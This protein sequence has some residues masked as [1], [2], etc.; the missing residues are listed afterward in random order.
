MARIKDTTITTAKKKGMTPRVK[1][2]KKGKSSKRR[3]WK[4]YVKKY[5]RRVG[6]RNSAYIGMSASNKRKAYAYARKTARYRF[7]K[8]MYTRTK[9]SL[10]TWRDKAVKTGY[11]VK[12]IRAK[13]QKAENTLRKQSSKV[14]RI[15][16][17]LGTYRRKRISS[18]RKYSS[19]KK[20]HNLK[21]LITKRRRRRRRS[22]PPVKKIANPNISK[23]VQQLS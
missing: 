23:I 9:K 6:K 13:L 5:N 10:K 15:T 4:S 14:V 8:V 3:T 1:S 12:K 17:R 18:R 16:R 20:Q 22:R 7:N 11:R 21:N 2:K 19:Y